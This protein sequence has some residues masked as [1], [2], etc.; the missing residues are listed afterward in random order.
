MHRDD[1]ENELSVLWDQ[2]GIDHP[3]VAQELN[4][5]YINSN[6]IIKFYN[7]MNHS[8][9]TEFQRMLT[10]NFSCEEIVKKCELSTHNIHG[11]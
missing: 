5:Q 2:H 8:V 3:R 1:R 4:I 6:I 7:K 11:L 9:N 10:G